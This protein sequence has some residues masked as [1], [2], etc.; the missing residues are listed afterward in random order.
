MQNQKNQ[1]YTKICKIEFLKLRSLL[2]LPS[3]CNKNCKIA[4]LKLQTVSLSLTSKGISFHSLISP[5]KVDG[6]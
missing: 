4:F 2:L 3:N 5:C 1:D 6:V